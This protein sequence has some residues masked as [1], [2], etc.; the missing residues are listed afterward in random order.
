M[1][2]K[3]SAKS[4][5]KLNNALKKSA[6][7]KPTKV[8]TARV[9]RRDSDGSVW[10]RL[11]GSN[12]DTPVNGQILS[13]AQV[14]DTVSV[15][16]E[17]GRLSLMGNASTP[18]VGQQQVNTTVQPVQQTADNALETASTAQAA[19]ELATSY[20][21]AAQVDAKRAKDAADEADSKAQAASDAA[22]LADS[23]AQAASDAAQAASTAAQIADSKA[24]AASTAAQIADGKADAA[25]ASATTAASAAQSALLGLSTVQDVVDVLAWLSAHSVAT[26]D[27]SA[28][29]NK[30]YYTRDATTGTMTRV[31][32]I[33][34]GANPSALGWWEMDDAVTQYLAAHLA[35]TDYGLNLKVDSESGYIHIGTLDGNHPYG[36]YILGAGN[37]VTSLFAE[38]ESRIGSEYGAHVR[39]DASGMYITNA[40]GV[41]YFSA[42]GMEFGG[43]YTTATMTEAIQVGGS[44]AH[45]IPIWS[46]EPEGPVSNPAL[47]PDTKVCG[48]VL[49]DLTDGTSLDDDGIDG[50]SYTG[51][52]LPSGGVDRGMISGTIRVGNGG[53]FVKD[54]HLYAVSLKIDFSGTATKDAKLVIGSE[55]ESHA[56]MD[57]HAF[58]M[59]DRGGRPYFSVSD[60][61]GADGSARVTETFVSSGSAKDFPL[62]Y[63]VSDFD[64]CT[65]TVSD[66]SG[67]LWRLYNETETE[68]EVEFDVPVDVTVGGVGEVSTGGSSEGTVVSTTEVPIRTH[69]LF[70]TAPTYD[71]VVTIAYDTESDE[72]SALT[73]G[74]RRE[75]TAPHFAFGPMSVAIGSNVVASRRLSYAEG[76]SVQ[77]IGECAHAEGVYSMASG[78]GS[79]SEGSSEARGY[80]SHAE[81]NTIASGMNSHS[82]GS[83]TEANGNYSHA[84]G[85]WVYANGNYSHAQNYHT[86][87][88]SDSQ[89]ALGRYNKSDTNGD[90]A[91]I[92]GNGTADDARSNALTVDWDGSIDTHNVLRLVSDTADSLATTRSATS[93]ESG[94]Y[95][96]D[97]SGRR[98]FYSE[99]MYGADGRVQRSFAVQRNTVTNGLWF[100]V[101]ADGTRGMSLSDASMWRTA[102]GLGS[103]ALKSSLAASDI[104]S[105]DASKIGSGTLSR[106]R[107]GTGVGARQ[108]SSV[109]LSGC[110]ATTNHCWHNGVVA[111][112]AMSDIEL[113]AALNNGSSV[114]LG[115]VP[116]GYRPADVVYCAVVRGNTAQCG[117][118]FIRITAAGTL[119]FYNYS[120]SQIAKN[121]SVGAFTIT[122]AI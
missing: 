34:E 114:Q 14:G 65:V 113:K 69:L 29:A 98:V 37:E 102:L 75:P 48:Y 45:Y 54:D 121:G 94:I 58:N 100:W 81:G 82:E 80:L 6:A 119:T 66:D 19:A 83:S 72:T 38:N 9:T 20:A 90:Y 96:L 95:A 30:A 32:V 47:V 61:R 108:N 91:L 17:N 116:S 57:Y 106:P 53:G 7:T 76:D 73:F 60:L 104:P 41:D 93:Y 43:I 49:H 33:P 84:E 77:S 63:V 59:I 62:T 15:R 78:D 8:G 92:I 115:T 22:D 40:N 13:D 51:Y 87:A 111:T 5:W 24:Q 89:T 122:Y 79:H 105:L 44:A 4:A 110:T 74:T 10:V 16:I 64:T 12:V 85:L 36:T 26:Q 46:M 67:G 70:T 55:S 39:T 99:T 3:L 35:M 18:S 86:I 28:V 112:V 21:A 42:T 118:M 120:G 56:E 2:E 23:K 31:A 109:S 11:P 25:S 117:K 1:A 88:S 52:G 97:S 103:L 107:G 101:N 27:T 50:F 68:E 71:A